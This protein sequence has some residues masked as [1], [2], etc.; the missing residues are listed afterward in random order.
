MFVCGMGVGVWMGVGC[1][2]PPV[3]NDIVT[4]RQLFLFSTLQDA[5]SQHLAVG[6]S[7]GDFLPDFDGVGV[8][9]W[10]RTFRADRGKDFLLGI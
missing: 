5:A 10:R 1:P 9:D 4:P 3:R 8:G 6:A 7:V 2:C